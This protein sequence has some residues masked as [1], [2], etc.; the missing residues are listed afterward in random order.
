MPQTEKNVLPSP[1]AMEHKKVG[2]VRL[3]RRGDP[4]FGES[5]FSGHGDLDDAGNARKPL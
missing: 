1:G 4:R 2:P 5:R 3:M